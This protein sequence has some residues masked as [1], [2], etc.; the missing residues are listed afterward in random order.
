MNDKIDVFTA[1]EQVRTVARRL[2]E[3]YICNS[4][5]LNYQGNPCPPWPELTPKV[6]SHW[7]ASADEAISMA[8]AGELGIASAPTPAPS[9]STFKP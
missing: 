6:Q 3:R 9:A 4:D 8:A 7:C 2:Y 1:T 5:G